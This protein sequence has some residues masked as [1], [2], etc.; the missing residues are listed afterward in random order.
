VMI[1]YRIRHQRRIDDQFSD[2]EALR[3]LQVQQM[4]LRPPDG[5]LQII[6]VPEPEILLSWLAP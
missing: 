4:A 5:G 6:M 2:P 3:R 1:R